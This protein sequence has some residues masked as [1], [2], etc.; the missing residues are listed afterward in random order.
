MSGACVNRWTGLMP[1]G[2]GLE[3][4]FTGVGLVL[5][6]VVMCLKCE[7]LW[8]DLNLDLDPWRLTRLRGLL[9]WAQHL[10]S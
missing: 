6:S 3:L 4:G 9:G 5:E 10:G 1:K 7:F 2:V 8:V